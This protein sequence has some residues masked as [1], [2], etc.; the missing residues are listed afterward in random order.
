VNGQTPEERSHKRDIRTHGQLLVEGRVPEMFFR[1]MIKTCGLESSLEA[2][3]FGDITKDNLKTYLEIFTQKPAFREGVKTLGII[4]DA[5]NRTAEAAFQSV[6]AALRGANLFAPNAMNVL[7]GNPLVVGVYI[8]PDC[9]GVG[10][11]ESLC[12]TAAEEVEQA[13]K[14]GVLP[15]VDDLF[16]CTSAKGRRPT[17]PTKAR[18]AGYLLAVDVIDPQLGRAAQQDKIP[19]SAK[20][21]DPLKE[22]LRKVAGSP[23]TL[24][25]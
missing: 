14:D 7:E 18:L 21:F 6:Q 13:G 12:H 5:E 8:L 23:A 9:H 2:R 15:C 19:W 24:P 25:S 20:A 4:L 10:M 3:T 17:N 22:F 11:L 16:K 1:E